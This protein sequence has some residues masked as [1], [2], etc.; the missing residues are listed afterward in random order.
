MKH[1]AK[2][3]LGAGC[4]L[5][6]V[7]CASTPPDERRAQRL[8]EVQAVAGEPVDS[9]WYQRLV[10]WEALGEEHLMI[11]TRVNEAWLLRVDRPCTELP[12][13]NELGIDNRN[14]RITTSFDSVVA[15]SQRCRIREIREVDVA[16]LRE[17]GRNRPVTSIQAEGGT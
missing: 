8:V 16:A 15:G 12:W 13:V 2:C 6:L 5:A 4:A 14:N 3:A 10:S 17:R 9:I 11:S 1:L 7:A